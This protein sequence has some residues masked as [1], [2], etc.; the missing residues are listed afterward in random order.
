MFNVH[1][2]KMHTSPTRTYVFTFQFSPDHHHLNHLKFKRTLYTAY[3][4][5]LVLIS[6]SQER[7]NRYV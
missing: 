1:R 5:V 7:E 3:S 6:S 2:E 4:S